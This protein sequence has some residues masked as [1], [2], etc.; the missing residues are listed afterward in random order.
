MKQIEIWSN[1][2]HP[3]HRTEIDI[4]EEKKRKDLDYHHLAERH[5]VGKKKKRKKSR[6]IILENQKLFYKMTEIAKEKRKDK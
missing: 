4:D 6:K 1:K 2:K 5:I 3:S